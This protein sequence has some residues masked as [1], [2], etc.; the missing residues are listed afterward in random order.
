M[1]FSALSKLRSD[2]VAGVRY[3]SAC[4]TS[5]ALMLTAT[6]PSRS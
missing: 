5:G 4:Y 6:P 2:E 3:W 1:K